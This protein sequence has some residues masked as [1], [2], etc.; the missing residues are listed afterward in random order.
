MSV[1][2]KD[3]RYTGWIVGCT[4]YFRPIGQWVSFVV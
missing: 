1:A 3:F 2:V 4:I